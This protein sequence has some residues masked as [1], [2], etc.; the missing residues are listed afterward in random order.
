MDGS[1]KPDG[2]ITHIHLIQFP[3][4]YI[5]YLNDFS[6]SC[7]DFEQAGSRTE[8][9]TGILCIDVHGVI[10]LAIF[11]CTNFTTLLQRFNPKGSFLDKHNT[12]RPT[13]Y[14][15]D[16]PTF[17]FAAVPVRRKQVHLVILSRLS[18]FVKIS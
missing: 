10:N 14:K 2:T 11:K 12:W 15:T 5:K 8:Y 13:V 3:T 18:V 1:F 17:I 6:V 16:P 4:T 9:C 7:M